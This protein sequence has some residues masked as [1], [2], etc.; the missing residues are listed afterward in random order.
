MIRS[1]EGFSFVSALN[2]NIGH[3]HIKLDSDAQPMP[4]SLQLMNP[5]CK[6]INVRAYT[7][8]RSMKRQLHYSKEMVIIVDIGFLE[9]DYLSER[10]FS[11]PTFF[12]PKKNETI[13]VV[14][15]F[16]KVKLSLKHC[17]SPISYSKD[18][19]C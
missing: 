3:N 7:V 6:P 10:A 8:A 1:M 18:W 14:T 17:V 9:E 13:R 19:V 5:N 12:I 16:R 2:I 15:D 11:F 4:I